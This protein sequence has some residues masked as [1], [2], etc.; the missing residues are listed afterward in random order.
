MAGR[1]DGVIAP[2]L[3]GGADGVETAGTLVVVVV[4][5]STATVET[6]LFTLAG[7]ASEDVPW[8]PPQPASINPASSDPSAGRF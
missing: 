8:A 7:L 4:A 2:P 3:A 6:G 5:A 1:S